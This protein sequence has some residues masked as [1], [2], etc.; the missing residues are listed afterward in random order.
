[1]DRS[2]DS[3]ILLHWGNRAIGPMLGNIGATRVL[4]EIARGSATSTGDKTTEYTIE[5]T[6][7][8]LV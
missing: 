3:S 5:G 8:V 7:R 6:D 4:L 1:M 2:E